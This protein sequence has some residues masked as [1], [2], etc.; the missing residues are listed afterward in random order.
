M[1]VRRSVCWADFGCWV[2]GFEEGLGFVDGF[3]FVVMRAGVGA[4]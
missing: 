4:S 3:V 2:G 1:W